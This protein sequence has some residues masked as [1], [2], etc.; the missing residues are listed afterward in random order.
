MSTEIKHNIDGS[1]LLTSQIILAL[2]KNGEIEVKTVL[3]LFLQF[4]D[5]NF[6]IGL[7]TYDYM[8]L[9]FLKIM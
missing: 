7:D 9:T 5:Q 3:S 1:Y 2:K 8:M 4:T 6:Q